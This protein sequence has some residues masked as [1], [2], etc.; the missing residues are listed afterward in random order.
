MCGRSCSVELAK[1]EMGCVSLCKGCKRYSVTYTNT[2]FCFDKEELLKFKEALLNFR[3]EDF[4][5]N[6]MGQSRAILQSQY[7]N[8]GFLVSRYD[9]QTLNELLNE[10]LV[11]S[12]V[13][14]LLT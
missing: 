1:N 11:M 5:Y 7:M 2:S 12:K 6:I 10:A 9:I 8:M 4:C 14:E 3:E 13:H